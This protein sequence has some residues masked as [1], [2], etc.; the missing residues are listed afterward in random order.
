MYVFVATRFS[1]VHY[2]S[3]W[4]GYTSQGLRTIERLKFKRERSLQAVFTGNVSSVSGAN[5]QEPCLHGFWNK[6]S[7]FSR[8]R[9][10]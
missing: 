10:T 9:F 8:V 7:S 4:V 1:A 3:A 5:I 6:R 2:W